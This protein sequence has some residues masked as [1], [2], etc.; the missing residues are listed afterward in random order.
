MD[1]GDVLVAEI[2]VSL[3]VRSLVSPSDFT[4]TK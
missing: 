1:M 3:V 4:I 2:A